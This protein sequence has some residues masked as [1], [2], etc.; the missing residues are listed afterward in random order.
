MLLV[1]A[2]GSLQELLDGDIGPKLARRGIGSDRCRAFGRV[3]A[4]SAA[5]SLASTA[6]LAVSMC[7]PAVEATRLSAEETRHVNSATISVNSAIRTSVSE[8]VM[9]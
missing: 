9:R 6:R 7:V 2:H 4:A 1:V 5:R 3:G 8:N